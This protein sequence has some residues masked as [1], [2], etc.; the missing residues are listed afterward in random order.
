[1]SAAAPSAWAPGSGVLIVTWPGA[2]AVG[3]LAARY[4][5]TRLDC[6]PLRR[7]PSPRAFEPPAA[8]VN[9]GVVSGGDLPRGIHVSRDRPELFVLASDWAPRPGGEE[10]LT[11][12]T[13]LGAQRVLVLSSLVADPEPE[14]PGVLGLANHEELLERAGHDRLH[15]PVAGEVRGIEGALLTAAARRG[16]RALT[17]L[18]V[19]SSAGAA[20]PHLVRAAEVL[21]ALA[22]LIEL[23]LDEV[24]L[25]R[26][27]AAL[28]RRQ[29]SG[30]RASEALQE[31]IARATSPAAQELEDRFLD[32][33]L[34]RGRGAR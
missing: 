14:P 12:A 16:L 6:T 27:A 31:H 34:S 18:G 4:L 23:E 20:T 10:V 28:Q 15:V 1:M 30:A 25:R 33:G 2:G 7:L 17:L 24:E 22:P 21:A 5:L 11:L 9:G 8:V 3:T 19:V 32:P 13:E 29:A 26:Q